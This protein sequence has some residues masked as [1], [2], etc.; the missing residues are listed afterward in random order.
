[1]GRRHAWR[2]VNDSG[3]TQINDGLAKRDDYI[4][5]DYYFIPDLYTVNHD[6]AHDEGSNPS[7]VIEGAQFGMPFQGA[8]GGIVMNTAMG[9]EAGVE[10]PSDGWTYAEA[11]LDGARKASDPDTDQWGTWARNDYEFQLPPMCFGAGELAY[12]NADE[13][14]LAVFDNGG[15]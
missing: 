1:M 6:H 12:R 9:E 2:L 11:F 15:D 13:T 10:F 3:F 4:P 7:N 5:E 8:L 14:G